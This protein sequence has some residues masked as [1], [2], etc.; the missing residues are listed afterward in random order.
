MFGMLPGRIGLFHTDGSFRLENDRSEKL[1]DKSVYFL[2]FASVDDKRSNDFK[3]KG[4]KTCRIK[5][6]H[7]SDVV[8]L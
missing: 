8:L 5:V 3:A 4:C 1:D 7:R 2:Y 6:C